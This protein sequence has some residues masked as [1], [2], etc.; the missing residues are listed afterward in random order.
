M[1]TLI[2]FLRHGEYDNPQNIN[3]GR[4]DIVHLSEKGKQD[5]LN[6]AHFFQKQNLAAIFSSPVARTMETAQIISDVCGLPVQIDERLTEVYTPFEGKSR[7]ELDKIG[8]NPYQE[9]Y[10]VQGG[11]RLE[12]LFTRMDAFVQ[13]KADE[14]SGQK[15]VAVSHGDPLMALKIV[16]SHQPLSFP[17]IQNNYIPLA[18]GF[19]LKLNSERQILPLE[20]TS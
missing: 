13:E 18:S 15:I 9:K 20:T 6:R 1:S 17:E 2:Y 3:P 19:C 8:W 14:F 7:I 12:E 10:Y 4:L 16:Y 11:E 5:I